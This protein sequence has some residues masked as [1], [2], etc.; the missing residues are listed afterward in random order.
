MDPSQIWQTALGELQLQLTG[1]TFDTWLGRTHLVTFEDETFIVGVHNCYAQDWLENRLQTLILRTLAG[2][3][4]HPVKVKFVVFSRELDAES[5]IGELKKV[6]VPELDAT[7]DS[8]P[9]QPSTPSEYDWKSAGW[10]P[11]SG[12]ES[13]FWAPLLGRVDWRVWEIIRET[14]RRKVKDLWTPD[15]R[16]SAPEL[17][18]LVPC[19]RHTITGVLRQD[20]QQKGALQRLCDLDL[21]RMKKQARVERDPHT[22]YVLSVRVRL[23]LLIPS[24]VAELPERLQVMHDTWLGD[25]GFDPKDWF[26]T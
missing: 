24:W 22:M 17:A 18:E 5:S 6:D 21:A 7:K 19:S 10:F 15:R 14:D 12:Y 16:W 11:V 23:P 2:I 1:A 26:L 25:H 20:G 4:G 8:Q 3:C 9:V 13:R